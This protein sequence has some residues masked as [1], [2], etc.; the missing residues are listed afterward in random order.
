MIKFKTLKYKNQKQ[1]I[2]LR[3]KIQAKEASP[4]E[5]SL[6]VLSL[7]ESWDFNDAETGQPLIL[8]GN[9]PATLDEMSLEQFN[10]MNHAFNDAMGA[11]ADGVKKTNDTASS[12]SSM[13]SKTR[14]K[15][16]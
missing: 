10:E 15:Q 1:A 6:F 14:K 12:S 11:S 2:V 3:D 8:N 9:L 13:R 5:I 4:D 7:I 16:T